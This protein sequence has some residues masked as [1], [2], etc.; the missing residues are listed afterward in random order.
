MMGREAKITY[1]RYLLDII[2]SSTLD[3]GDLSDAKYKA[4]KQITAWII[5][6]SSKKIQRP[7]H[8]CVN[9]VSARES[10]PEIER[11]ICVIK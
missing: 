2:K 11:F 6:M 7:S 9:I 10:A 1:K 5:F 4:H 3:R 8:K